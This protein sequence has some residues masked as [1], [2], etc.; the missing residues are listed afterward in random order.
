MIADITDL[1]NILAFFCIGCWR[2]EGISG[3]E[4]EAVWLQQEFTCHFELGK[5]IVDSS[6]MYNKGREILMI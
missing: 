1:C 2:E 3:D 6:M 4:T 5:H